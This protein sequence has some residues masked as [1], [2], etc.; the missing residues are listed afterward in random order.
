MS[1]KNGF[2]AGFDTTYARFWHFIGFLDPSQQRERAHVVASNAT[3]VVIYV[4]QGSVCH[5][6]TFL[7]ALGHNR[8]GAWF[9]AP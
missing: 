8:L 1:Q 6:I 3:Q 7:Q 9:V 4:Y 2:R 5:E